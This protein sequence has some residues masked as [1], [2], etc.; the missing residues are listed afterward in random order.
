MLAVLG[1]MYAFGQRV[2]LVPEGLN[3][4]RKIDRFAERRRERFLSTDE[5]TRL[6]DAIREG[7]TVGLPCAADETKAKAKHAPKPENRRTI[8]DPH[9]AA[10]IRLLILTGARLGEILTLKW[11][12]VDFERGMLLL[13]DSKIGAKA[14]V[15]NARHSTCSPICPALASM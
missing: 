10:A 4:S 8:I 15:L 11:D 6:G 7:E 1:S 9:V 5:L 14:I 13:P 2:G 3:P 12:H